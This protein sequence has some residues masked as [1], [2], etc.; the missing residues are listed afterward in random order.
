[1]YSF[2]IIIENFLIYPL[3]TERGTILAFATLKEVEEMEEYVIKLNQ[4]NNSD[5]E[6]VQIKLDPKNQTFEQLNN[7]DIDIFNSEYT[8]ISTSELDNYDSLTNIH[9]N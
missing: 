3:D 4:E 6:F 7:F 1:M 9:I 2:L 5:L 8:V